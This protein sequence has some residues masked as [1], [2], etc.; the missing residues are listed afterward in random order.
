M[1][2]IR[3]SG[4][5][6]RVLARLLQAAYKRRIRPIVETV[7]AWVSEEMLSASERI[8]D[9]RA[10]LWMSKNCAQAR[11]RRGRPWAGRAIGGYYGCKE[12][13]EE[14]GHDSQAQD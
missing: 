2:T 1:G 6:E 5:F 14:T 4:P 8:G 10:V 13:E 9:R 11:W 12:A 3:P 7:P